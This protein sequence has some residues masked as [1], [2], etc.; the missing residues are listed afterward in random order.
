MRLPLPL[1]LLSLIS[2]AIGSPASDISHG[3]AP[4]DSR[5]V[6]I[7]RAAPED[8]SGNYA[9]AT[10]DCPQQRPTIRGAGSLSQSERDWLKNR[11]NKTIDPLVQFLKNANLT[12]FDAAGYVTSHSS[13]FSVVPNIGIAVS[14][15]GYRALM[16]G[17]GFL[18]AADSR[19][20]G[21]TDTG[22]IGGLLQSSTYL[23]GLSGGG[24][25]VGSIFA[26]NFSSVVQLRD[27]YEGS[28]LWQFSNSIF[29]GPK[30]RGISIVNTVEY[31]DDIKNQVDDKRD[32]GY[33]ASITDYWGRALSVQLINAA[34]GGPAYTFSSIADAPNFSGADTP[35]PILVSDERRP[36]TEV[37]SLNSTVIEFN[38]W[39]I[40]SFDPTV[41]GF[42]PIRYAGSN[43]SGGSVP[44]DG[45]CVEGFD[46]FSFVMGT[47]STLFNQFLLQNLSDT[48]IPSIVVDALR[49]ILTDIGD[50]NDDIAA[51]TPNP[52]YGYNNNTNANHEDEQLTLVDG[53]EDLQNI[54]LHP[55]IQPI[56][57]LDVI[58]AVDS[59]ADTETNF[60]NGTALRATYDRSKTDIA[61]GTAFPAVPDAETFVNLGL[62]K[63][64]T[65][66]GCNT[67][68][69]SNA[70]HIPP[71]IV[72]VPNA[73]YTA[74]SNVSTFDPSYPDEQRNS[75][76]KNGY[77]VAT[78]GNGTLDKEWP[79]CVACAILSRSLERTNTQLSATCQG[80]FSR[81]C[82]NG[83]TDST[84]VSS[85][86]P[87]PILQLDAQ[88][89]GLSVRSDT[90]R[91]VTY[92]VA[93]VIALV[94][95][96]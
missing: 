14:G 40:G 19:V 78:M 6:M 48:S 22:G 10:V 76:I 28:S 49:A 83:T 41:F 94:L 27:G 96:L 74:Q 20:P 32:A 92:G 50:N 16:N 66:F 17:A 63:K 67:S 73:P 47:S 65:F 55:L 15:G 31:W 71:L 44:N 84:P 52:F 2:T 45:H 43:F 72:Y 56:R 30:S 77:N 8:P 87:T 13:N 7:G 34:D 38:P 60:P 79:A 24:W 81:Y 93:G 95:A 11:R 35:M 91:G 86:D 39:E 3:Y 53:G 82:W 46:S 51:W 4:V 88:S 58:F 90:A 68:D 1:P 61:N 33:D 29:K 75:I 37:V 57:E 54:P 25:L 26:N 5:D 62:N 18:A 21:A 36:N 80:C 59:S 42:A 12:D 9:P 69:F 85:Y 70:S 89:A 23:A 64:P